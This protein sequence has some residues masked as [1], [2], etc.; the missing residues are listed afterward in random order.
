MT[1]AGHRSGTGRTALEAA[2][3][4]LN[5]IKKENRLAPDTIKS[6]L[7]SALKA[8]AM[9]KA[10][11]DQIPIDDTG[12]KKYLITFVLDMIFDLIFENQDTAKARWVMARGNV[13][14]ILVDAVFNKIAVDGIS[15]D[16]I[17][18][19]KQIIEQAMIRYGNGE[20]FSIEDIVAQINQVTP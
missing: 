18:K 12:D 6:I 11:A 4:S 20:R 3:E 17:Q 1:P 9:R 2:F 16:R 7:N 13:L 10:F 19:I 15:R 14:N 5:K 8:V